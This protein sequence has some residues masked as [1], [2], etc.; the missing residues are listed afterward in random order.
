MPS[1]AF[2]WLL[3]AAI[4]P[5]LAQKVVLAALLIGA[6][7]GAAALLREVRPV[8]GRWGLCA[9]ALAA[10]WNPFV[11][12]R[13]VIGQWTVLLGYAVLPWA[14]RAA[15]RAVVGQTG[16]LP[17]A[18]WLGV[19]G[20]GGVN[21]V[22]LVV[23]GVFAILLAGARRAPRR[24]I[25]HL[26]V[27][28]GATLGI[29]AAWMVPSLVA[30][31][32]VDSRSVAAF[33]PAPDTPLGVWG[34]LVS[35]GGFWNVAAHPAA[36]DTVFV[37]VTAAAL[38]LVAMGIYL[39]EVRRRNALELAAP[40]IVGAL[41]VVLSALPALRTMWEWLV[42]EVP[43]GGALRDSQKFLAPWM[44]A[45]AV[46][47]GLVVDS[48]RRDRRPWGTPGAVVVIGSVVVLSSQLV[49]GVGGR[50]DAVR[51]PADY[52][53]AAAALSTM[54]PGEVG[55]LPWSQYRRYAWNG[56]RVSLT[57]APRMI[58]Q[59]V[60][61]DDSLPLRSGVISGES[62]RSAQVSEDIASGLTPVAA[63]SRAGVRYLFVERG[64]GFEED[65]TDEAAARAAGRVVAETES[66]L[67]VELPGGGFGAVQMPRANT[68]GWEITL[69]T[70][71]VL[72]TLGGVRVVR[73]RL[74]A[75]LLRSR[76]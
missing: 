72:V 15:R 36:R 9:A 68:V 65:G 13:L 69:L 18:L 76:P 48:L 11:S 20:V 49:W 1:D 25:A 32:A 71:V 74:P 3:G 16:S 4:T 47:V 62:P 45:V 37:S 46:G 66:V 55:V 23:L 29:S 22:L 7:L 41:V 61:S 38:S 34:S 12:E 60:L 35:G 17:V 73:R 19:S 40:V 2:V 8:A 10:V 75:G 30:E 26:C 54:P 52:R 50:L 28:T 31:I 57:L 51:V 27:A 6:S 21:S 24:M 53:A 42:T 14:V 33:G 56:D 70:S 63:L 58:D 43:G 44:V 59:R 5:S 64:A 67:L 39:V